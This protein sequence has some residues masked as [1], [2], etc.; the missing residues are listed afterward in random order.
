MLHFVIISDLQNCLNNDDYAHYEQPKT[1]RASVQRLCYGAVLILVVDS[2]SYFLEI[3]TKKDRTLVRNNGV[4]VR[5]NLFISRNNQLMYVIIVPM[6]S[7]SL[8]TMFRCLYSN[9]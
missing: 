2:N 8:V 6:E 5:Q 1:W 7:V 4:Q 3:Y 9:V